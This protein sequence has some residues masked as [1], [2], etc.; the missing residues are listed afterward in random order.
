[1]KTYSEKLENFFVLTHL[2]IW[3]ICDKNFLT[4]L[5]NLERFPRY[6]FSK[7][8]CMHLFSAFVAIFD[9]KFCM[10]FRFQQKF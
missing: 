2:K 4:E 5:K 6:D 3:I 7:T 8:E 10:F 1:M 9:A